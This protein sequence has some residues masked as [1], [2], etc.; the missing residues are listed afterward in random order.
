MDYNLT[1]HNLEYALTNYGFTK[2]KLGHVKVW[3]PSTINVSPV[4]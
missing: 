3:P 4:I 1:Y 2:G